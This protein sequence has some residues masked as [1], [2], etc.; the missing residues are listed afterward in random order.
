MSGLTSLRSIFQ[1]KGEQYLADLMG[2]YVVVN[3]K[4]EGSYFGAMLDTSNNFKFFKK[5]AEISFADRVLN[6]FY[7]K[8][9]EH[10]ESLAESVLLEIPSFYLFAMQYFP[11]TGKLIL[12]HIH[13]VSMDGSVVRTIQSKKILDAWA[14][15]LQV[16]GP[17]ILFEGYLSDEQKSALVQLIDS[18]Q[19]DH[20]HVPFERALLSVFGIT[21]DRSI[22][23]VVFRFY[24]NESR[25]EEKSVVAKLA[26]PSIETLLKPRKPEDVT[27]VKTD[28]FVWLILVD[29]MNY[30]ESLTIPELK[31]IPLQSSNSSIRY[32]EL[33]NA[34][35]KKYVENEGQKWEGLEI[36]IPEFLRD[37]NFGLNLDL[38]HD[39]QVRELVEKSS[40]NTEI[41]RIMLNMLRNPNVRISSKIFTENMKVHLK[42]QIEKL[43]VIVQDKQIH[44]NYFPTF[45]EFL[46]HTTSYAMFED[47]GAEVKKNYDVNVVIDY[48]QPINKSH[49]KVAQKLHEKNGN[50]V[51]LVAVAQVNDKNKY[52]LNESTV[53]MILEKTKLAY[54]DLIEDVKIIP[55]WSLEAIIESLKSQYTPTLLACTSKRIMDYAQHLEY[56]SRRQNPLVESI[57]HI[58][59]VEVDHNE[60]GDKIRKTLLEKNA[61]DF[62]KLTPKSV[63]SLFGELTKHYPGEESGPEM[64]VPV[65][66][67][68][69]LKEHFNFLKM[70]ISE[71]SN[72]TVEAKTSIVDGLNVVKK[73][74]DSK[75][76][77]EDLKSEIVAR[78]INEKDADSFLEGLLHESDI[79]NEDLSNLQ[80]LV[81]KGIK[82]VPDKVLYIKLDKLFEQKGISI[83]ILDRILA[84][85]LNSHDGAGVGEF[86]TALLFRGAEKM[87]EGGDVKINSAKIEVKNNDSQLLS[88][89]SINEDSAFKDSATV[90][91]NKVLKLQELIIS[92][93]ADNIEEVCEM[94]RARFAEKRNFNITQRG[95]WNYATLLRDISALIPSL[96]EKH[97]YEWF[98]SLFIGGILNEK[99]VIPKDAKLVLKSKIKA[100][101]ESSK[102][103]KN[104]LS[105]LTYLAFKYYAKVDEFSGMILYRD[106]NEGTKRTCMF[107]PESV[108]FEDYES[109][110]EPVTGPSLVDARTSKSFKIRL[111]PKV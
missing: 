39:S 26:S 104:L 58:K 74:F 103:A 105:Y 69:D 17:A 25:N 37:P 44:E 31:E 98:S 32:V 109:A 7:N 24:E 45:A 38:I 46:G 100:V 84:Q 27:K 18:A 42:S 72:V 13:E 68:H 51:I 90:L 49:I 5:G 88:I 36:N 73:K 66:I 97:L 15:T 14:T 20:I 59:L 2:S 67:D 64:D 92:S 30:I 75:A 56:Y 110:V 6:K 89:R 62:K 55:N 108:S 4:L 53:Q 111:K 23:T 57:R 77:L 9:I 52:P 101:F 54:P 43:T 91:E 71:D 11:K 41:Y 106:N 96:N 29:V 22:G 16:D 33:I 81:K 34:L 78:N 61:T 50:K 35:Y 10:F 102:E 94:V 48:F 85:K 47:D 76:I 93:G 60:F 79:T 19:E 82:L 107:I 83:K 95:L 80:K 87:N 40:I 86:A 63:H 8:A 70:V 3:E 12:S 21:D 65:K 99:A 1:R 28:D